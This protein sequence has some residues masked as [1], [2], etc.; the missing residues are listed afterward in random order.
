MFHGY[1]KELAEINLGATVS[2]W[3]RVT[4]HL[5]RLHEL[6]IKSPGKARQR[7][8]GC[9]KGPVGHTLL[10]S[11]APSFECTMVLAAFPL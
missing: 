6:A 8:A 5:S 4:S 10:M 3:L 9:V 11:I 7:T 1:L 2:C